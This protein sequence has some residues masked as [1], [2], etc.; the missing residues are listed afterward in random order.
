MT[1]LKEEHW[2]QVQGGKQHLK[3]G[4]LLTLAHESEF[5][6]IETELVAYEL[7]EGKFTYAI[8]KATVTD[9]DGNVFT[10]YGDATLANV[11][12]QIAPHLLRMSETRSIG[13][14][15]RMML[16]I[17]DATY[18]EMLDGEPGEPLISAEQPGAFLEEQD[19]RPLKTKNRDPGAR[20]LI[21]PASFS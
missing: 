18:E 15:L 21:S 4:G 20:P 19:I 8:H 7:Q 12:R 11:N 6:G 17:G 13:R 16:N 2:Q 5:K 3:I 9:S 10:G 14:A 1:N